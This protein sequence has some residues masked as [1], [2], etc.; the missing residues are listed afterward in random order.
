MICPKCG[1]MLQTETNF[2]ISKDAA[3]YELYRR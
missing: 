2:K 3:T 1:A